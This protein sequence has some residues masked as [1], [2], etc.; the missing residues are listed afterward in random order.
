MNLLEYAGKRIQELR[1]SYGGGRGISQDELA[2]ALKISA[3]TISRWETAT[4]RP[5]IEDLET[6]ARFFNVSIMEFFPSGQ[7]KTESRFA[8]LLRAVKDLPDKDL[9]ELRR[10]A[11]F[12]KAGHL[13]SEEGRPR[14]GRKR[15]G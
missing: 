5:S 13:L 7:E 14:P 2:K 8:P 10:F 6:L 4:Y 15:K 1:A 9:D 3:N 11:E 12:R